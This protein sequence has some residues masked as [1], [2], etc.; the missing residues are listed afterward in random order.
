MSNSLISKYDTWN[1]PI[2][3][4]ERLTVIVEFVHRRHISH[5]ELL[6]YAKK[7]TTRQ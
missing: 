3:A 2:S 4:K 7:L 6:E 1:R 5:D